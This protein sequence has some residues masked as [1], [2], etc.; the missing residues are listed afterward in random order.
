MSLQ[1][2]FPTIRDELSGIGQGDGDGVRVKAIVSVQKLMLNVYWYFKVLEK[3]E[4]L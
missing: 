4:F 2:F 1:L 3:I